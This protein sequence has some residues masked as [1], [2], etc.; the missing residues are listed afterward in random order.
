[1]RALGGVGVTG[2]G[3]G[4]ALC[5]RFRDAARRVRRGISAFASWRH[6]EIVHG[7]LCSGAVA[8]SVLLDV[9]VAGRIRA[10]AGH[11]KC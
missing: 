5:V 1:M 10:D 9:P 3:E 7:I 8:L 11:A 2:E 6:H 4:S